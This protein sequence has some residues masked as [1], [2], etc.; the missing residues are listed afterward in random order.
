[1]NIEEVRPQTVLIPQDRECSLTVSMGSAIQCLEVSEQGF[2]FQRM[3]LHHNGET[4]FLTRQALSGS[5]WEIAPI[6]AQLRFL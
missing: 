4:F 5:L 3:N 2:R 6:G 1:M